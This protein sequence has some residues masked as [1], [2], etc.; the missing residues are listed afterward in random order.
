MNPI[1]GESN[2]A[3][4]LQEMQAAHDLEV[5][6]IK[7][8]ALII[9]RP[10]HTHKIVPFIHGGKIPTPKEFLKAAKSYMEDDSPPT[11][12]TSGEEI[13]SFHSEHDKHH[14]ANHR[15]KYWYFDGAISYLESDGM[16][17]GMV[18]AEIQFAIVTTSLIEDINLNKLIGIAIK[19]QTNRMSVLKT[20]K[21]HCKE[22]IDN[23]E[24]HEVYYKGHVPLDKKINDKLPYG[25]HVYLLAVT[26]LH[27]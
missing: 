17:Y 21:L 13:K 25:T 19:A 26:E 8:Q 6:K 5:A 9:R 22:E 27:F 23:R 4:H 15:N 3:R 7:A 12:W 20:F 24:F 14:N 2:F 10:T 11:G 1:K 18:I 16:F